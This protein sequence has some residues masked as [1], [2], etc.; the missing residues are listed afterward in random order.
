M[1]SDQITASTSYTTGYTYNLSGALTEET[2]PSGR[3]V[4][5]TINANGELSLVEYEPSGGSFS[6]RL[7]SF[8][9]DAAGNLTAAQLGN[10]RWETYTYNNRQQVTMIGLGTTSSAQ[11][12]LRLDFEYNTSG[13]H[14]NN[15]AMLKQTITVPTV[16]VNTGFTATQVYGYDSLNRITSA[17][18]TISSQ[19]WKQEFSYDRYGN[20]NYVTGSGHTTTLGSCTTADCNPT[21]STSTNRIT[22]SGYSY[23]YAGSITQNSA[24][25]R[26][27]YDAEDHQISYF[28]ALNSGSTPDSTYTYDGD[29]K[30]VEKT[31]T[32]DNTIFVYDAAGT[33]IEEYP[34]ATPSSVATSYVYAGSQIVSTE[35]SSGTTSYLTTDNVGSTRAVTDISGNVIARKDYGAFG[36]E[37]ITSQRTTGLGYNPPGTRKDYTGY[38]KDSESG[39]EFAQARYENVIHG[40][41]TSVD[42]LPGSATI[43]DPQTFNRYTYATN[44]PYKFTDPLG[45]RGESTRQ[46]TFE[47]SC[48]AEYSSCRDEYDS[49]ANYS[50]AEAY[51]EADLPNSGNTAS[52][53]G[54]A[55]GSIPSI[56]LDKIQLVDKI[57]TAETDSQLDL[58]DVLATGTLTGDQDLMPG[59]EINLAP[60]AERMKKGGDVFL[61]LL[62]SVT[63]AGSFNPTTENSGTPNFSVQSGA[64]RPL[65]ASQV[66]LADDGKTLAAYISLKA[67]DGVSENASLRINVKVTTYWK[68][69]FEADPLPG[70]GSRISLGAPHLHTEAFSIHVINKAIL[71]AQ[72]PFPPPKL[73][74]PPLKKP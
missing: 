6:N 65:A 26:F 50:Q 67:G 16:G 71:K 8:T 19:T 54:V 15:G 5:N 63:D 36:D 7:S 25:E 17:T 32:T 12:L 9:R 49:Y 2:Y 33:L 3:H 22:S 45:L 68:S 29:G 57:P 72:N 52:T 40:R 35:N 46:S 24:G 39:L 11:D 21:I 23:D 18:E 34:T 60:A 14:D 44:S 30:R 10:G 64:G 20:K 42:P 56:T 43:R 48:S 41:F 37:T 28:N 4:R 27:A 59:P 31:F 51:F 70:G 47:N 62:F 66:N 73:N 38:E 53:N 13:N 74:F 55:L 58:M 61:R 69:A 1:S